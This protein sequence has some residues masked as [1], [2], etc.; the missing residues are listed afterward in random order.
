VIVLVRVFG[1]QE[2]ECGSGLWVRLVVGGWW[3]VTMGISLRLSERG[4]AVLRDGGD[5]DG[6]AAAGRIFVG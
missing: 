6:S 5:V 1:E 2:C 3:R 4:V